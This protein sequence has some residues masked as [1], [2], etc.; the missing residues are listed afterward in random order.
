MRLRK[1]LFMSLA[2]FKQLS[3]CEYNFTETAF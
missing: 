1:K 3:K 2:V